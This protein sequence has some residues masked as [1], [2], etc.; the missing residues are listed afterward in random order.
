MLEVS[1][2]TEIQLKRIQDA[3]IRFVSDLRP[4]DSIAVLSVA[5]GAQRLGRFSL[6]P[7]KI[8]TKSGRCG[9]EG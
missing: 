8:R 5:D 4:D 6:Y 1:G 3:A 2:S 7:L 9:Q